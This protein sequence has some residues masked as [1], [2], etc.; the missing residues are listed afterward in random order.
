[1]RL[2]AALFVII[3]AASPLGAQGVETRATALDR[4]AADYVRVYGGSIDQARTALLAQQE[5][6]P[7]TDA[8]AHEFADRLVGIAFEQQ[9]SPAISVLLTGDDPVLPRTI[10]AG[11]IDIPILFRTG[12]RASQSELVAA[13]TRHQA[14]LRA[15]LARPPGMGI[16]PRTGEVVILVSDADAGAAGGIPALASRLASDMGVPVR[17]ERSNA[18]ANMAIQ[19]GA[20]LVGSKEAGGTRYACTAGYG[21]TDGIRGAMLTAAHCPDTLTYVAPDDRTTALAFVGQWGWGY[22][23]VQVNASDEP[24]SPYFIADTPRTLSRPVE[25]T[26]SRA[27][28]RAGDVVCHRG[29]RTGYSC[30]RVLMTD[31]APAGDLCGGACLP[32]WVAVA[33]PTC[34]AGDSGAPVFIGTT[35]LGIVKGGTYRADGSCTMYFYMSLDYVPTGWRVLTIGD[36]APMPSAHGKD[37]LVDHPPTRLDQ[38]QPMPPRRCE[39]QRL[40]AR[41]AQVAIVEHHPRRDDIA[42]CFDRKSLL[43]GRNIRVDRID[44]A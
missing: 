33:G 4:D 1:M 21:V 30:A 35:A 28:T 6:V 11:G 12:A 23:D 5:S 2:L 8:L 34:L 26:Q 27:S 17:I 9:P 7:A 18:P 24:V 43:R 41:R 39:E 13:I 19:G 29:E 14:T 32:T 40:I 44:A 3:C 10:R 31:F 25:A 20:R 15:S 16:D 42:G 22:Q 36:A 37:D 38:A